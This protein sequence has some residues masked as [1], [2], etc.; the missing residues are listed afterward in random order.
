MAKHDIRSH[1]PRND[2]PPARRKKIRGEPALD[3]KKSLNKIL[4][5]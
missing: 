3:K 5:R 1:R 2:W 4:A